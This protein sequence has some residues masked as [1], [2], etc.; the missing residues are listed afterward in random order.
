[1]DVD[2]ELRQ[3]E[4]LGFAGKFGSA[5]AHEISTPLNVIAGRIMLA[6]RKLP[7][8]SAARDDLAVMLTQTERVAQILR[9]ALEPLRPSPPTLSPID[10]RELLAR[11]ARSVERLARGLGVKL[12]VWLSPDVGRI[13]ADVTQLTPVITNILV[14]SLE[15]TPRGG[16]VMLAA[17]RGRNGDRPMLHLS[18]TDGGPGVA[19]TLLSHVFDPLFLSR[20]RVNGVSLTLAAARDI[21]RGHDGELRVDS[22]VGVGTTVTLELP[23]LEEVEP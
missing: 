17:R 4:T 13:Q 22:E 21:L 14:N 16:R 1:M 9:A 6:L 10:V 18:I 19:P 3:L 12:A 2:H 8:T 23:A 7:P 5:L 20:A 15:T 11:I